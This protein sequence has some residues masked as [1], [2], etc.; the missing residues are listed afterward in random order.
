LK[1]KKKSGQKEAS[2][3]CKSNCQM[4]NPNQV[5]S[6]GKGKCNWN[7]QIKLPLETKGMRTN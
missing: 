6:K 3:S 1:Q 2:S 5:A 7:W 4:A